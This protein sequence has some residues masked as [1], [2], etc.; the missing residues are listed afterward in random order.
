MIDLDKQ[1]DK[2]L[3][4]GIISTEQAELMRQSVVASPPAHE[5]E[6]ADEYAEERRIPI[7][8]EVLGY[9]GAA[10]AIWAV[11]FLVS[12]FW[13]NIADWAQAGL[14]AVVALVLFTSGAALFNT[15]EPALRRLST[16]LWAGSVVSLGGTLFILFDRF[17]KLEPEL[18]WT[19]IGAGAS[20]FGGLMMWRRPSAV[21]HAV[22]FAALLTTIM[23]LLA[24]G[25]E[26]EIFVYGF[27]V[28]AY[29]LVWILMTRAEVLQPRGA[30]IGLGAAAMLYGAQ[31][32]TIEGDFVT[33]GV[34][35][36]LGTAGLLAA[37]GI[38]L[39]ER[40]S[41]ILGG[42]GIFLFVPQSMFHFFG[43][44]MGGMLGLF[45]SGLLLVGL[46]I[47]FGRHREAL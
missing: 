41:I 12:E 3:G 20:V 32:A 11:I 26:P 29:G 44:A 35:L 34:L 16:V 15:V 38:L 21:Q 24:F 19:L 22:L 39:R 25:P 36:G 30:G 2:W 40:L 37:A 28:W 14:F 8:T 17:A 42:L 13:G 46:A 10:L 33:L 9:V 27:V 45:V 31:M 4:D 18:T 7:V 5:A 6:L 47:W 43:E 1:L 23:S